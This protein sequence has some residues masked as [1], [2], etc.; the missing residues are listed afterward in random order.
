[1]RLL[2][3][4]NGFI[5]F[6][7]IGKKFDISVFKLV[8]INAILYHIFNSKNKIIRYYDICFNGCV[9]CYVISNYNIPIIS[10]IY[11]ILAIYNWEIH[12][13][14][15]ILIFHYSFFT[16]QLIHSYMVQLPLFLAMC[17]ILKK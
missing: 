8:A 17:H 16:K 7:M 9:L 6:Y 15:K 5:L 11:A 1:M 14:K 2:S 12:K 3:G 4:I 10:Y 13:R